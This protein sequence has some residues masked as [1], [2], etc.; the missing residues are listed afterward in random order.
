M[1]DMMQTFWLFGFLV[2]GL[3]FSRQKRVPGLLPWGELVSHEANAK[4]QRCRSGFTAV[5]PSHW[6]VV[7]GVFLVSHFAWLRSRRT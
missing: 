7:A 6:N 5:R 2:F 4:W 3:G 1:N